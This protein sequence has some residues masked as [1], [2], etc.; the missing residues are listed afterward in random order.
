MQ[1]V[2]MSSSARGSLALKKSKGKAGFE[3]H[4]WGLS[5]TAH[6]RSACWGFMG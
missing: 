3:G 5:R 4:V 2:S 1:N 6:G